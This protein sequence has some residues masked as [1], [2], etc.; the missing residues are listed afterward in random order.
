MERKSRILIAKPGLDGHDRGARI[1]AWVLRNAGME[2]IYTGRRQRPEQIVNTAIQEDVDAIGLSIHSGA[3]ETL[4]GKV[5]DLLKERGAND[6]LIFGGGIISKE[7][8]ESLKRRGVVEIFGPG[9]HTEDIVKRIK[10]KL[11]EREEENRIEKV[12]HIGI[13]V[14]NLEEVL[15]RYRELYGLEPIKIERREDI[16]V[17]IALILL[18]GVM[19]ELLEPLKPG[20]GRIG[21]FIEEKGEGF[22]HI[23]LR[24]QNINDTMEKFKEMNVSFRDKEPR[25]GGDDARIAFIE[26]ECTQNVLTELVERKREVTGHKE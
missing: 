19:I 24:V 1:I 20:V 3:H 13:A 10:M 17:R 12:D 6:I 26:P 22:H 16:N 4:F 5:L 25:V 15:K 9:S 7:D 23:A 8:A 21:K 2:V 14:K 11:H 18:G